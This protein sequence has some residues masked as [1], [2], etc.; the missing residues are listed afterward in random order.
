MSDAASEMGTG[1]L[2]WRA[3][4]ATAEA[5]ASQFEAE[6][7]KARQALRPEGASNPQIRQAMASL[8]QA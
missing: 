2:A 1:R 7:E 3:A 6:V 8:R 4:L 5:S